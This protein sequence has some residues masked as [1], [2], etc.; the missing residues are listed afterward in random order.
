MAEE[1][2]GGL[3]GGGTG[4]L[5]VA[6][7]RDCGP[8]TSFALPHMIQASLLAS[9]RKA[10]TISGTFTLDMIRPAGFVSDTCSV[11]P[12]K[13]C[14]TTALVQVPSGRLSAEATFGWGVVW[15]SGYWP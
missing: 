8:H 7:L 6:R 1:V 9:A 15:S 4:F 10:P 5:G 11:H 13:R 12:T 14:L 3:G 2:L